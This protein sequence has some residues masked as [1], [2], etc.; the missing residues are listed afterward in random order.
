MTLS[1]TSA[2]ENWKPVVGFEGLYEVSDQG[3]VRSLDHS[4]TGKDG[5]TRRYKGR[6]LVGSVDSSGRIQVVLSK[7]GKGHYRRVHRLV[8]EAFV[9]PCPPG[10]EGCHWDDDRSNN[11]LSNLRWDTSSAN[12]MDLVRNGNHNHARKTHCK[13][14][15][16][17]TEQN[18]GIRPNGVRWCRACHLRRCRQSKSRK[19]SESAK[20]F[21]SPER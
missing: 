16:E 20:R 13:H 9:G 1:S 11:H 12:S 10:Y 6:V 19:T 18:T 15:H 7:E 17:F 8:L 14:G 3:R 21:R 4:T 2:T 5:R